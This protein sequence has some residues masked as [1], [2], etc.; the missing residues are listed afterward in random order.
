MNPMP[1]IRW[2]LKL[3]CLSLAI[4]IVGGGCTEVQHGQKDEPTLAD[5][6]SAD[7]DAYFRDRQQNLPLA[8][9]PEISEVN[10][11]TIFHHK[12]KYSAHP[13]QCPFKYLGGD[14]IIMGFTR[15]TT[16]KG[17]DSYEG[18]N[19]IRHGFYKQGYKSRGRVVVR[20]SLDGG[21]TWLDENEAM[22]YDSSMPMD[23]KREFLARARLSIGN[24]NR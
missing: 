24:S 1:P 2:S 7:T 11:F 18:P 3:C 13:R 8:P 22:V 20:P 23:E 16:V 5:T 21:A 12:S 10:H 19:D 17:G 9:R 15:A 14:E 6:H 4:G